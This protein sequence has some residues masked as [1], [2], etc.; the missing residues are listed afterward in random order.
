MSSAKKLLNESFEEFTSEFISEETS[1][2]L[3]DVKMNYDN[4]IFLMSSLLNLA[5]LNLALLNLLL[6]V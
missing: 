5:L 3:I 2:E 6:R 4:F 1:S